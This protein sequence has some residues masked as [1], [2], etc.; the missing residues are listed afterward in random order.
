MTSLF[1][2]RIDYRLKDN[3]ALIECLKNSD[4]IICL[5]IFDP[6]QIDSK[7]INIFLIIVFNL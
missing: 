6:K 1:I 3:T 5:F 7:K 2:F 4:K